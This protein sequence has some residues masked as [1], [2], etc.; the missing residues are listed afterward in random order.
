MPD[1]AEVYTAMSD[2]YARLSQSD[3]VAYAQ[4]ME[5]F[6]RHEYDLARM[7]LEKAAPGLPLFTPVHVGLG[8]VYEQLGDLSNAQQSLQ[9]AIQLDP[10]NYLASHALGRVQRAQG[11][12]S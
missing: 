3:H 7:L 11:Q 2:S 8:L 10:D 9:Q 5:A 6:C 12:N 4:G 1:Y